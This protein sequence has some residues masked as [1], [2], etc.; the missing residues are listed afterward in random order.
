MKD[1]EE[2]EDRARSARLHLKLIYTEAHI[3][4]LLHAADFQPLEPKPTL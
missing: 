2:E 1:G 3:V 4:L